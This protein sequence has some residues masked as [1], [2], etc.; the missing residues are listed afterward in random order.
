MQFS[1]NTNEMTDEKLDSILNYIDNY[2]QKI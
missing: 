2:Q 1:L